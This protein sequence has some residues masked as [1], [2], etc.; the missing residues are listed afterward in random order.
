MTDV[1]TWAL[2]WEGQELSLP[3]RQVHTLVVGSGAA[4]LCCA[5]R[6]HRQGV[7]DLLIVTD[8]FRGGT[9]RNTGSDKQTYYKLADAGMTPDSPYAMAKA[10]SGGGCMHGD[11]ALVEAQNSLN[12]FY[13]LISLGV[14]FPH[15]PYGG[16]TGYKTDHDPLT[17]GVS[18]G[19]YTSKAMTEALTA[20][21]VRRGIPLLDHRE[22]L[23]VLTSDS[24]AIGVLALN[25]RH[26]NDEVYGLEVYLAD[27]TVLGVG[28][29]G[30]LYETSVYP[31]MQRGGIGMALEAGAEA[32]NL[33]ES[34]FG[35]A[36][37]QFR[38]NLSG[39]YQQ[40]LP[41]YYSTDSQG[42][43][44]QYFLSD[45]FD[46]M[47]ELCHA[48]FLKGYQWPFD[49]KKVRN[50]GSSL[51]DLLVY[52]EREV[53]GRR[54]F[55][56]FRI[57]PLGS[58]EDFSLDEQHSEVSDYLKA[59]HVN[60]DTP[61]ERLR[62]INEPAI[63][64]YKEHGI[65]LTEEA[66]EIAVCAQ[67]N[68]GG[69]AGDLWW[70]S[71]NIQRLFPIGEVNGSHGVYRPGGSALNSGQVGALRAATRIARSYGLAEMTPESVRGIVLTEAELWMGRIQ[72]LLNDS[73]G[74]DVFQYRK[75]FQRRM[76][77][78]G[79]FIRSLKSSQRAEAEARDQLGH[80]RSQ[81]LLNREQ[82]PFALKNRQLAVAQ[83][84][85]LKAIRHYLEEGGGS[86]GS[87]LVLDES[88]K[89]S[90]P[91]LGSSWS[92]KDEHPK[93]NHFLQSLK[94]GED[95]N[96]DAR[97]TACRDLPSEEFWFETMWKEYRESTLL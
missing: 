25:K 15:N 3:V 81:T 68:N 37:I 86:R 45:Y 60:G 12:S 80:F 50:H 46:S 84:F 35:I 14:D 51:I 65:D 42:S 89:E 93:M 31:P 47:K 78:S 57:N 64:L 10:L 27:N 58:K 16:Y 4:S 53:K 1:K 83:V 19:P 56:D 43:D 32:V 8:N 77:R 40:V 97:F 49:P 28:G 79:G 94:L 23:L 72:E 91:L 85:Y 39:S 17:R 2:S 30:G 52:I 9:S 41:C 67:H 59:S 29:P 7:L 6:L 75:D 33:T 38:W 92:F 36:S 87:F 13:H 11:I 61:L 5:E 22:V 74:P 63:S 26:L 18:L 34:Q 48:L 69:L 54:V 90:H 70:E 44:R 21:V 82:I 20:E 96:I 73:D 88:G 66:L 76:T 55:M 24:K 62:Q 71:T 95:W